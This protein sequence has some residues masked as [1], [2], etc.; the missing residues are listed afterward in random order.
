MAVDKCSDGELNKAYLSLTEEQKNVLDEH[1]KKG[2]KTKW[3]NV[4]AKNK[5]SVLTEAELEDTDMAMDKLLDWVLLDY[6]DSLKVNPNTKCECG[7]PL[8]YRYTVLHKSTGKIYKLGSVHFEHHTGLSPEMVRLITKGIK[9][10]NLER[11]E[12]LIKVINKWSFGISIPEEVKIP[13]DMQEQLRIN[14]PLLD[15]QVKRLIYLINDYNRQQIQNRNN[16]NQRPINSYG[17]SSRNTQST[18]YYNNSNAVQAKVPKKDKVKDPPVD[19]LGIDPIQLYNKLKSI[20]ITA[21][22]ARNLF[23]F[24]KYRTAEFNRLGLN[25]EEIKRYSTRALGKIANVNI[26]TWLVEIEY[27]YD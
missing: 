16:L 4:W 26:R 13:K 2:M 24:I 12:I 1:I 5:G 14:L 27:F 11:A 9:E 25:L 22:E 20:N 21:E 8:R 17:Q 3:L 19:L 15:R 18:R 7:R 6:E 10:I 23:Y